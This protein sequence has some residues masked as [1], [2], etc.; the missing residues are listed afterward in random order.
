MQ[1]APPASHKPEESAAIRAAVP[2]VGADPERLGVLK[3]TADPRATVEV[4]GAHFHQ[5]G[6]TPLVG[7]KVPVGRYQIVFRNDTFGV[8][9]SAQVMVVAGAG[10]G[11]HADFRQAE[12][13]ISVR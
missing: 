8:P 13:V 9:L 6:Q 3:I 5:F 2:T 4:S 7:L 1:S 12:P 11:V 10:R